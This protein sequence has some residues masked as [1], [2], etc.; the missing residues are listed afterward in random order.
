[1]GVGAFVSVPQV[2]TV[3]HEP[4][5]PG[6]RRPD[7]L[8]TSREGVSF[9]ADIS[10]VSDSGIRVL[11]PVEAFSSALMTKIREKGLRGN[12]F[13]WELRNSK[14]T[15]YRGGPRPKLRLCTQ[16]QF[17]TR[18]FNRD[19]DKFLERVQKQPKNAT[20]YVIDTPD[21]YVR[22]MYEP[23]QE[24]CSGRYPAFEYPHSETENRVFGALDD[25]AIQLRKARLG[26]AMGVLLCDGGTTML[27]AKK[28]FQFYSTG[29]ILARFFTE[30]HNIS[31]VAIFTVQH[32]RS[33][34]VGSSDYWVQVDLHGNPKHKTF[35]TSL[36]PLFDSLRQHLPSPRHDP[37][38]ARLRLEEGEPRYKFPYF[39]GMSMTGRSIRMSARALLELLAGTMSVED[40]N[41]KS[42]NPF[43][44]K[45]QNGRLITAINFHPLEDR[46]DDEVTIE[47]GEPD[48]I[49]TEFRKPAKALAKQ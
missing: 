4:Q 11:Y 7:L 41:Y 12:S 20:Q 35:A 23:S 1:M 32:G 31:F 25:K 29:E 34:N 45:L 18:I 22:V 39:G 36:G 47:F 9:L 8:F 44:H 15:I 13:S 28:S 6:T 2:G 26:V 43:L 48:P 16:R 40:F 19:F 30:N 38:N 49:V 5:C 24:F 42:V 3:N 10:V 37:T 27:Q 14:A 21:L 33:S 46:D 17:G